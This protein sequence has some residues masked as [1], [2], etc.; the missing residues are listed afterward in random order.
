[1]LNA[2]KNAG[3]TEALE[4]ALLSSFGQYNQEEAP[5]TFIIKVN[6][7]HSLLATMRFQEIRFDYRSTIT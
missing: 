2:I 7:T 5:E 3:T 1:M 6:L 4:A